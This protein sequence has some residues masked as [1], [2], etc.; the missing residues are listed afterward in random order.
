MGT[1]AMPCDLADTVALTA[2]SDAACDALGRV[3]VLVPNASAL[4]LGPDLSDWEASLKVDLMTAVH[5]CDR[6]VPWM[7]AS[8]G[9]SILLTSSIS[10][11]EADPT[12]DYGYTAA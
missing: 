11:L 5:A 6:V 2:F 12:P 10:G 1:F 8:G 4:A 3:D 7:A 9:G